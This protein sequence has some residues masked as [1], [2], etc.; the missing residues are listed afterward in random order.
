LG[1]IFFTFERV[2]IYKVGIRGKLILLREVIEERIHF[3]YRVIACVVPLHVS[4]L[5]TVSGSK[6]Y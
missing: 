2:K 1:T 3:I 5:V 4:V 6:C